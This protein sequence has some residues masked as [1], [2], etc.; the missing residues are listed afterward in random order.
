MYRERR[1]GTGLRVGAG[2]GEKGDGE[3]YKGRNM[4]DS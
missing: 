3:E 1:K 2:E 4:A